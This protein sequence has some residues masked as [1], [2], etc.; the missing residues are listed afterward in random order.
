MNRATGTFDVSGPGVHGQ[1]G[2]PELHDLLAGFITAGKCFGTSLHGPQPCHELVDGER[3]DQVVVNTSIQGSDTITDLFMACEHQDRSADSSSP[4]PLTDIDAAE[5]RKI[6]VQND[7]VWRGFAATSDQSSCPVRCDI[8]VVA[9]D[10]E[11]EAEQL[12]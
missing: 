12:G 4:D 10:I 9:L 11:L 6:P 8:H 7:Q 2:H 1:V 3:L 5:V